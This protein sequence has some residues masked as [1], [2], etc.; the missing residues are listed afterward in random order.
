MSNPHPSE[1]PRYRQLTL[2]ELR[3]HVFDFLENSLPDQLQ[4]LPAHLGVTA[5][6]LGEV[7]VTATGT[8]EF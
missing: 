6:T 8:T 3:A 5:E 2:E 1:D 4:N 7:T